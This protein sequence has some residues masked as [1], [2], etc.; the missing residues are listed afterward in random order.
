MG[1]GFRATPNPRP[2]VCPCSNSHFGAPWQLCTTA[3]LW[4]SDPDTQKQQVWG[5][6]AD[7]QAARQLVCS[8]TTLHVRRLRSRAVSGGVLPGERAQ[9]GPHSGPVP[10]LQGRRVSA[11]GRAV[12]TGGRDLTGAA[13]WARSGVPLSQPGLL[14]PAPK[15]AL[16]SATAQAGCFHHQRCNRKVAHRWPHA[17]CHFSLGART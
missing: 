17:G 14:Q 1:C 11:A 13:A 7:W 15:P 2:S 9:T 12:N 3:S 5:K 4:Q 8:E 16:C 10:R 6:G